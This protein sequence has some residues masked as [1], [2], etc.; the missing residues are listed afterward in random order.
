ML[1]A[2]FRLGRFVRQA[3]LLVLAVAIVDAVLSPAAIP[4]SSEYQVK[5]AFLYNFAKFVEWP[6]E[7]FQTPEEPLSFCVLGQDPFGHSL[8]DSVKGQAIKG[9][10]L[11]VRHPSN[12]A[13]V[14]GC[15]VLY[16]A[17]LNSKSRL[18]LEAMR[19]SGILIVADAETLADNLIV[20]NFRL[21]AAKVRF[22][23]NLNAAEHE[24][25][26]IS[27]RLLS[28]ARNVSPVR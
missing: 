19:T 26:R 1:L 24:K 5:A 17:D 6:P 12:A 16:L 7:A 18:Q 2:H 27:S 14:L 28:L 21:E 20:I 11:V 3:G 23:I 8:Q 9:R 13:G 4:L 22:E 15:H 25:L 10:S